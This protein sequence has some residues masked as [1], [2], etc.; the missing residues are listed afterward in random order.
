MK[1]DH[2]CNKIFRAL[3]TLNT[4]FIPRCDNSE[5]VTLVAERIMEIDDRLSVFKPESDVSLINKNAGD[6]FVKVH[7]ETMHLLKTSVEYS[8]I[9]GNAFDV[10]AAPLVELWGIG[11]KQEFV[12]DETEISEACRLVGC[13][14]LLFDENNSQVMLTQKGQKI[15]MGGIA[16]GYAA[17]EAK[18][19]LSAYK[20]QNALIN[21]GGNIIAM[22]EWE[23]KIPW[24]IG[25]QNPCK[26]TGSY[27]G[28]LTLQN[29]TAVTSGSNEQFFIK[30]GVRYHHIIDPRT[31]KPANTDLL[32]VTLIGDS[33]TDMDAL[34]TAIFVL[35][36]QKASSLLNAHNAQAIFVCT[37]GRV[38]LTEGLHHRFR[39]DQNQGLA[40]EGSAFESA[41]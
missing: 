35:G 28:T 3:G 25:I 7:A 33:S 31:G 6:R 32:S 24:K 22:G 38:Y 13:E 21:L 23:P 37:D 10:T 1:N 12:P 18:K 11:K 34:S 29:E 2:S 5:A 4:I 9:T 8:K 36:M 39:F 14:S 40:S 26:K 19:I 27:F 20:I 41:V 15:C 17:D 16:K 30:D